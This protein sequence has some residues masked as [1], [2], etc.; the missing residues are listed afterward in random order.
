MLH[1]TNGLARVSYSC[2]VFVLLV[3]RARCFTKTTW[4]STILCIANHGTQIVQ[5]YLTTAY[6]TLH[7]PRAD[8]QT[9]LISSPWLGF[10]LN[11]PCPWFDPCLPVLFLR[12]GHKSG[13]DMTLG[14]DEP[15]LCHY[16]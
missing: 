8:G 5:T 3:E 10:S 14:L 11:V 12:T 15:P 2:G 9:H 1:V 7:C 16:M 6:V 4:Q 13:A